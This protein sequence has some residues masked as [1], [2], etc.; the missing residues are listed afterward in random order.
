M[1]CHAV[2]KIGTNILKEPATSN[3]RVENPSTLKTEAASSFK[4]WYLCTELRG[5]TSQ[6]MVIFI[7][8]TV[9]SQNNATDRLPYQTPPSHIEVKD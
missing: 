2:W 1:Q 5:I 4:T 7:Y 6:K 8:T 9:R 3:F